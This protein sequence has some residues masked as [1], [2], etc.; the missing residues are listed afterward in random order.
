M[1]RTFLYVFISI[2]LALS[3]KGQGDYNYEMGMVSD[4]DAYL[5]LAL[6]QYYTNGLMLFFRYVPKEFNEKLFNKIVEFRIGQKIYNPFQGYVP[7]LER[8]DKPFAG[9]LFMETGISRFYRNE[10]IFK[11]AL[12]IGILGPSS[13][14]EEVQLFYHRIF[15]L[16]GID[17]WQYQLHDAFGINLDLTYLKSLKSFFNRQLDFSFY[18][19][20]RAGTINDDVSAGVLTRASIYKLHPIY[21]SNCTGSSISRNKDIINEKE[22]FLYFQPKLS[23]IIY[24][25]TIQ[26][27]LFSDNSPVTFDVRPL[28]LFLELGISGTYKNLNAGYSVIF[29][30]KD[31][32]NDLVKDH[33][34]A[35]IYLA[36]RF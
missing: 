1:R 28:L 30:T 36:Y 3:S 19:G 33:V 17:G 25:A 13:H 27:G 18:S 5:M 14:A 16:Y 15:N 35:S 11:T 7:W 4:N 23:Y 6:D 21:N 22:L 20:I 26:G 8:M 10:S 29:Q 9:Y 32:K 2:F 34:Y 31:A 12:Q 24:D